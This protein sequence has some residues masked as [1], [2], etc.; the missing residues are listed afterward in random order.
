[1]RLPLALWHIPG[2]AWRGAL[3]ASPL[4]VWLLAGAAIALTVT[5][6]ALVW[7]VWRGGWP[8]RLAGQQL[9]IV[10][11]ALLANLALLGLVNVAMTAVKVSAQGPGGLRIEMEPDDAPDGVETN[12]EKS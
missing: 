2:N 11:W 6:G 10:G 8:D 7:I 1:M 5:A 4:R 3:K 9:T 12:V